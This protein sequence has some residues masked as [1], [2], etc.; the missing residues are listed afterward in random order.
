MTMPKPCPMCGNDL[1]PAIESGLNRCPQCSFRFT[2]RDLNNLFGEPDPVGAPK[3]L[4]PHEQRFSGK[5][6]IF[7]LSLIALGFAVAIVMAMM[8]RG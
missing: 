2:D 4:S 3:S 5:W 1:T 8:Q 6:V 7:A